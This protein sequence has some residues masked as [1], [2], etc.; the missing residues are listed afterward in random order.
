MKVKCKVVHF[1]SLTKVNNT[2]SKV[3]KV[4]SLD[5][6]ISIIKSKRTIN[7][8]RMTKLK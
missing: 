5:P 6:N 1:H 2:T 3:D 4:S 8:I 7:N